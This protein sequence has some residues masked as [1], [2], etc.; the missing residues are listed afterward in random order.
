LTGPQGIAGTNLLWNVSGTTISYSAGNIGVGT[1]TPDAPL[2]V[3]GTI[4][5]GSETGTAE[6]PSAGYSGVVGGYK[7]LVMRR[8][9]STMADAGSVVARTS[10]SMIERDGTPGGLQFHWVVGPS[11]TFAVRGTIVDN[12][13]V[14]T[15]VHLETLNQFDGGTQAIFTGASGIV[16]AHLIFGNFYN[17]DNV[18]EVTIARSS[19]G[20]TNPIWLGTV[21][22]SFD[23]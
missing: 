13:G 22:S 7:G 21:T 11:A 9:V 23:Q 3:K 8:I 20:A 4:R 10:E 18:T 19:A 15:G 12:N 1:A 14:V 5:L 6:G 16:F 2:Q 17:A